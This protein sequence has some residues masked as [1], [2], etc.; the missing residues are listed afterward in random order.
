MNNEK[1]EQ[2]SYVLDGLLNIE[3]DNISHQIAL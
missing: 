3:L 2:F 1:T